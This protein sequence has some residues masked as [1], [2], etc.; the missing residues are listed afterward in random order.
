MNTKVQIIEENKAAWD[1]VKYKIETATDKKFEFLPYH[2]TVEESTGAFFLH[3]PDILVAEL[4]VL[5][6]YDLNIIEKLFSQNI[7]KSKI[8]ILTTPNHLDGLQRVVEMGISALVIKPINTENLG[9]AISR[10]S[11]LI[12]K[13]KEAAS[14][15]HYITL[16]ANRSVLYINQ[17]DILFIE[18]NRNV[19]LLTLK[20]GNYK[21]IN[22]SISSVY[23]R[24]YARQLMR[25]D[26]STIINTSKI[27]YL[28]S[29]K[30]S[31]ECRLKLEDGRELSKTI[32]KIGMS[33][34]YK[35]VDNRLKKEGQIVV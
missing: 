6:H 7:A 22:E 10:V 11:G 28:G 13:D 24:L 4:R 30:Y 26:K 9:R 25:I 1:L 3:T 34:L 8:I 21:T 15:E 16:R 31:R 19:C 5:Y 27:A 20:D 33:R 29:D 35:I 14:T 17:R 32:S 2:P 23:E 12:D 18:S